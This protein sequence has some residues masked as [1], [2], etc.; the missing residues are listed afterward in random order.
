MQRHLAVTVGMPLTIVCLNC[1]QSPYFC[2]IDTLRTA[3]DALST[4]ALKMMFDRLDKVGD[5]KHNPGR[6]PR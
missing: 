4:D 6:H 5:P 1:L 2:C 3:M